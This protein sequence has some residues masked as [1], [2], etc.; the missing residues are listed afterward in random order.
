[1]EDP[2]NDV[3][4][5]EELPPDRQAAVRD[6]LADD[7][8]LARAFA[9]W[10]DVR[11]AIRSSIED[12]VPSRRLMVLYALKEAGRDDV[13]SDREREELRR[14]RP[15]LDEALARHPGL[16]DVID[17]IQEDQAAF[18]T[19]WVAHHA[20]E[21]APA[22]RSSDRA[23][24]RARPARRPRRA[25]PRRLGALAAVLLI[26]A[27]GVFLLSRGED[28]TVVATGP[29]EIRQLDLADGTTVRLM[30]RSRLQYTPRDE[31]A[32]FDRRVV[33]TAGRAFFDVAT[34]SAPFVVETPTARAT[35]RGT[36]FGVSVVPDETEVVLASGRVEV[37]A[38]SAPDQVVALQPGQ[39]SR[40][41]AD[42]PPTA[43]ESVDVAEALAWTDLFIF[44]DTPMAAIADRLAQH[45]E[46]DIMV[47][48]PLQQQAVT[49]TFE[50]DRPL[51]QILNTIA[52]ALGAQVE[53]TASGYRIGPPPTS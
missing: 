26:A 14:A 29:D 19:A 50:H 13:L 20:P 44:R 22:T 18:E 33:L 49:G 28:A 10:R 35:V 34:A 48:A 38:R 3:L 7:P 43:P 12:R 11:A 4:F 17:R 52:T 5:F 15:G 21:T 25:W 47:A 45:Y 37:A 6:A 9:H 40:V 16:H 23:P 53:V 32:A 24:R 31:G 27:L 42:A 30:A 8:E 1:M 2:R 51:D 46:V 36:S 39:A 41:A